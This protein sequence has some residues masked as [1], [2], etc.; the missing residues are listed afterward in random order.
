MNSEVALV[1]VSSGTQVKPQIILDPEY[2][3]DYLSISYDYA[4]T[5]F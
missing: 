3:P 5:F 1:L 4:V 2:L